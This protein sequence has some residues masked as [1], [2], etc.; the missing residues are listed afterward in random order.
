MCIIGVQIIF[1]YSNR[2]RNTPVRVVVLFL[3]VV[4]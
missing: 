3:N 1:T 4:Y 2:E